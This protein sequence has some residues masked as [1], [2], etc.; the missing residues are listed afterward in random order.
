M[1]NGRQGEVACMPSADHALPITDRWRSRN[2]A[3]VDAAGARRATPIHDAFRSLHCHR[4][5]RS[6]KVSVCVR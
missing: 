4:V 5:S 2:R 1:R 6:E 3:V